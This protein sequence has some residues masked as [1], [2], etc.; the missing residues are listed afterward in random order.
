MR[1]GKALQNT[2][3]HLSFNNSATLLQENEKEY[4]KM[5]K[6]QAVLEIMTKVS[7]SYSCAALRSL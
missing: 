3:E 4:H 6:T 2:S 5:L 7:R 1:C